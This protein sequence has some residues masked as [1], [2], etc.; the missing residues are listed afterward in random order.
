MT[1]ARILLPK[2]E[3][4]SHCLGAL[5]DYF[6]AP[7]VEAHRALADSYMTLHVLD[8]LTRILEDMGVTS[9]DDIALLSTPREELGA[10]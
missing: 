1:L 8:G 3:V 9:S 10:Y 4:P 2:P 6:D 7:V 5:A